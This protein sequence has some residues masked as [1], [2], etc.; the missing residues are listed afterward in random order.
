[1]MIPIR[2]TVS[3]WL[4]LNPFETDRVMTILSELAEGR[5][6]DLDEATPAQVRSLADEAFEIYDSHP[7]YQGFAY[8]LEG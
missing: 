6:L 3:D 7:E 5:G 8:K 2:K 1:M 4:G